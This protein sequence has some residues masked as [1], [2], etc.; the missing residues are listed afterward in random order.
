M[1]SEPSW[2]W[3][4]GRALLSILLKILKARLDGKTVWSAPNVAATGY[5]AGLGFASLSKFA[6]P[7]IAPPVFCLL[8][9][10]V[11]LFNRDGQ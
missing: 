3:N 8:L 4:N 7:S 5:H 9:K 11:G 10:G 2:C 1:P 6:K